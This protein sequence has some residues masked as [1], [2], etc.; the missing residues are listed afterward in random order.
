MTL[1]IGAPII[2]EFVVGG[3]KIFGKFACSD[4]DIWLLFSLHWPGPGLWPASEVLH[5]HPVSEE[6][7]A[8]WHLTRHSPHCPVIILH[9]HSHSAMWTMSHPALS[10]H[11]TLPWEHPHITPPPLNMETCERPNTVLSVTQYSLKLLQDW[12]CYDDTYSYCRI[13]FT[14]LLHW[15]DDRWQNWTKCVN[16]ISLQLTMITIS[17]SLCW[18]PVS[19]CGCCPAAGS[20]TTEVL[21]CVY[22]NNSPSAAA[23][24]AALL[25]RTGPTH[26]T[27]PSSFHHTHGGGGGHRWTPAFSPPHLSYF[28]CEG[29]HI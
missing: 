12:L 29:A 19:L 18:A 23:C 8:S 5:N 4:T 10:Y 9:G 15:Y 25:R 24:G 2:E 27:T 28:H 7:E 17:W 11:C 3:R 13:L 20:V 14:C 21:R 22:R 1:E 26:R 16:F 6:S